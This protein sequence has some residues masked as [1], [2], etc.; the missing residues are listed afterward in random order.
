MQSSPHLELASPLRRFLGFAIDTMIIGA[1]LWAGVIFSLGTAS[2]TSQALMM[3]VPA[4]YYLVL[5]R[6]LGRTVGKLV[7]G[8][9]VLTGD[10]TRP[11]SLQVLWRTVLRSVPVE[12]V[13][14]LWGRPTTL[15]DL[16]SDTRVVRTARKAPKTKR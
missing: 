9:R 4:A 13:L 3:V 7:T 10:G 8:T 2:T 6:L 15:H 11:S 14:V 16:V 5:E 12:S 1:L